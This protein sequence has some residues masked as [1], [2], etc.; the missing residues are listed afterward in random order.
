[1]I[2]SVA[3]GGLALSA[4]LVGVVIWLL[5]RAFGSGDSERHALKAAADARLEV[6]QLKEAITNRDEVI[7]RLQGEI[8]RADDALVIA[9][10]RR[11]PIDVSNPATGSA[12]IRESMEK[13]RADAL[14][15]T[16][17]PAVNPDAETPPLGS[18]ARTPAPAVSRPL[19]RL[20]VPPAGKA[21]A[22]AT[23]QRGLG[24]AALPAN[25]TAGAKA[26]PKRDPG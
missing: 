13:L 8:N 6:V 19:P 25:P 15:Q 18:R 10:E 11:P 12:A 24:D 1:M 20:P 17:R 5:V 26:T 4:M 14:A 23:T 21:P 2:E 9:A 22:A 7:E 16:P 3:I